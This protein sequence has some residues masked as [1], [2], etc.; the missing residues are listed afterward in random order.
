RQRWRRPLRPRPRPSPGEG[1][2]RPRRFRASRSLISR[3]RTTASRRF[4]IGFPGAGRWRRKPS[5]WPCTSA[6]A[7]PLA[8]GSRG[9]ENAGS[10]GGPT[11]RRRRSGR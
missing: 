11:Q 1:T 10:R 5:C 4:R 8:T 2:K 6:S 7:A 9:S 3:E